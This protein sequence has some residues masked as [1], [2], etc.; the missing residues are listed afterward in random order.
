MCQ[1]FLEWEMFQAKVVEKLKTH[2]LYPIIF[3][4]ENVAIYEIRWKIIVERGRTQLAIQ[5]GA[6]ALHVGYPR[7]QTLTLTAR[8][9]YC[10]SPQQRL[11]EGAWMLRYTVRCLSC[12]MLVRNYCSQEL[13]VI[14]WKH[15]TGR[16]QKHSLISSS[17]KIKTYWNI[18]INMGP[19][20]N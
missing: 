7:M 12:Y 17:Y 6:C 19:Q 14:S 13:Y 9:T 18:F 16:T 15:Y 4:L 11:Y 10:F 2:I 3:I 8:S 5:Y 1:F 20:I